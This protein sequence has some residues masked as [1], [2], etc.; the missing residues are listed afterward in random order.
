M[1]KSILVA[2][3]FLL[4]SLML[5]AQTTISY[6]FGDQEA[7]FKPNPGASST[8]FLPKLTSSKSARVR[9]RTAS[10]GS[11]EFNLVKQGADFIKGSGLEIVAGTT[12][13]KLSLYNLPTGAVSKTAFN[14]KFDKSMAGQWIFANGNTMAQDDVFQ[15]NSGLKES[16]TEVF[17]GLRWVLS[18][19]NEIAFYYRNGSK[20]TRSKSSP[21]AKDG[22]Y[23]IEIFSN[24]SKGPLKFS[25][26]GEQLIAAG[27]YQVWVNGERI[28]GEFNSGG[29][30]QGSLVNGLLLLGYVPKGSDARPKLWI[31]NLQVNESL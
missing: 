28:P 13:S 25:K 23:L 30:D 29:L 14:L 6:D 19:A 26:N 2:S 20:W 5:T 12:T 10:D 22:A 16:N 17:A 18:E 11:G 24:N 31:D 1:F 8:S 3:S 9:V 15:G 21:F 7:S 4:S 27:T